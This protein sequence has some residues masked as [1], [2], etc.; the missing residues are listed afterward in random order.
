MLAVAA[1]EKYLGKRDLTSEE[2][3]GVLSGG[4]P[5]FRAIGMVREKIESK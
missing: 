5:S 2:L 3:Q 1:A 4:A